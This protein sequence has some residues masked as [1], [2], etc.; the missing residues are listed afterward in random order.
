MIKL[1]MVNSRMKDFYDVY[2]LSVGH[3]FK[4]DELK[5]LLKRLSKEE[6]PLCRIFH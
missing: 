1:S 6:K 2:F 5:K 4:G 3:N